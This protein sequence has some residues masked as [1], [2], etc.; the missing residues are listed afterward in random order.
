MSEERIAAFVERMM[1][2]DEDEDGVLSRDEVPEQMAERLFE[3]WDAN[4]DGYLDEDEL[5]EMA[6]SRGSEMRSGRGER[7]ERP[8]AGGQR[9]RGQGRRGGGD[10]NDDDDG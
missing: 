10:D 1:Q 5:T 3:K 8:E 9:G 6:K 7:G 2:R 4:E